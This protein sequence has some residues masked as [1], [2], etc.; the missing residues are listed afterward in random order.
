M[1]RKNPESSFTLVLDEE[2]VSV[3]EQVKELEGVKI[4]WRGGVE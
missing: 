3:A 2:W 1:I 4:V